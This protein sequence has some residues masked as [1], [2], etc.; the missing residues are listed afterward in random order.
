MVEQEFPTFSQSV[1]SLDGAKPITPELLEEV[2]REVQRRMIDFLKGIR[3][4][5][6]TGW[7]RFSHPENLHRIL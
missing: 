3:T 6:C 4:T 1:D 5:P 2:G 7:K